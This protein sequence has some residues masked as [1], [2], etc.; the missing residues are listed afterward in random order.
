MVTGM[1]EVVGEQSEVGTQQEIGMRKGSTMLVKVLAAFFFGNRK[2][3][4]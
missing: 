3:L 4:R 2:V 1:Q